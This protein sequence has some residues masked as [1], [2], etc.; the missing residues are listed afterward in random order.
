M[1]SKYKN[2]VLKN[3][4]D[5]PNATPKRKTKSIPTKDKISKYKKKVER[6]TTIYNNREYCNKFILAPLILGL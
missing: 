1:L 5:K 4:L 2:I 6:S 3:K